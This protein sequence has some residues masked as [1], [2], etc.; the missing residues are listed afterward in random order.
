[1]V[2]PMQPLQEENSIRHKGKKDYEI[3]DKELSFDSHAKPKIYS[4]QTVN[5]QM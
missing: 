4:F 3:W 5:K 2:L 1:M